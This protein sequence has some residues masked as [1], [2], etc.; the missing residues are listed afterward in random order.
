MTQNCVEL[1]CWWEACVPDVVAGSLFNA[2]RES[3]WTIQKSKT[4]PQDDT[5]RTNVSQ[6]HT[7]H[8]RVWSALEFNFK[9][10]PLLSDFLLGGKK[11]TGTNKPHIPNRHP[12]YQ[13]TWSQNNFRLN[14][15]EEW[16]DTGISWMGHIWV[17]E[18]ICSQGRGRAGEKGPQ[19][20]GK[21]PM[22]VR[23]VLDHRTATPW[24]E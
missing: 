11:Q 15:S 12:P 22:T 6:F 24:L 10:T 1:V 5:V 16:N 21:G 2:R 20:P 3:E 18:S 17:A 7:L 14:F 13:L 19:Y 23:E 4:W 9:N 8:L